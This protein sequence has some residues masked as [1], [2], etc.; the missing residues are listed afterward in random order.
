VSTQ[1]PAL[2][3][4]KNDCPVVTYRFVEHGG[5]SGALITKAAGPGVRALRL[6]EQLE[7]VPV[8]KQSHK[9]GKAVSMESEAGYDSPDVIGL[10]GQ[11]AAAAEELRSQL[12]EVRAL[13]AV[14]PGDAGLL[15]V[16]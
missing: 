1:L 8:P 5:L 14:T 10:D 13:L 3:D 7:R 11:L 2:Y 4:A 15:Q 9:A 6:F 12:G 16:R